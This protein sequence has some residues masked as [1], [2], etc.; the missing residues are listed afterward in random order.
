MNGRIVLYLSFRHL[1]RFPTRL[2][3][4]L[5]RLHLPLTTHAR[6]NFLNLE[7]PHLSYWTI[8]DAVN[9]GDLVLHL[10]IPPITHKHKHLPVRILR[11]KTT[12][13]MPWASSR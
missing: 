11:M 12:W 3:R 7:P 6:S 13:W 4:N 5:A 9:A 10:R 8:M 2:H 1:Y